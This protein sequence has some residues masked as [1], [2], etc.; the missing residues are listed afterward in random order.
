MASRL[1][2]FSLGM[3]VAAFA[4]SNLRDNL[5][6]QQRAIHA[7]LSEASRGGRDAGAEGSEGRL[8]SRMQILSQ[9]ESESKSLF[10]QMGDSWNEGVLSIYTALAGQ[11]PR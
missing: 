5:F 1:F 4:Y 11:R 3:G 9:L 10:K 8:A 6:A 2:S 7:R